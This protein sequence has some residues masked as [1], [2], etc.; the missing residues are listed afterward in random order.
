MRLKLLNGLAPP[1]GLVGVAAA[2]A[3]ASRVAFALYHVF[4]KLMGQKVLLGCV[5]DE[6]GLSLALNPEPINHCAGQ[7]Q[8]SSSSTPCASNHFLE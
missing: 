6:H 5:R 2:L 3:S 1:G 8:S 4:E 7:G